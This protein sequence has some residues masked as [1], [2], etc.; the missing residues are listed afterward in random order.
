MNSSNEGVLFR[1]GSSNAGGQW[2]MKLYITLYLLRISWLQSQ[3]LQINVYILTNALNYFSSIGDQVLRHKRR[4]VFC[5]L[6]PV[7]EIAHHPYL[8]FRLVLSK[9]L[10]KSNSLWG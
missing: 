6:K 4:A 9:A 5:H 3:G 10:T 8:L 2:A 1:S 7:L